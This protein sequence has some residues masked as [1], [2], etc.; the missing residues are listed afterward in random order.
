MLLKTILNESIST[1]KEL[2]LSTFFLAIFNVVF[3]QDINQYNLS[4]NN[5]ALDGYDVVSYFDS[6]KPF[7]GKKSIQ[8]KLNGV[9]YYFA[10]TQNRDRFIK[11]PDKYYVSYG[12]WCAYAMGAKNEKVSVD[13]ETYKIIGGKLYLFYNS[14]YNNTLTKWNKDQENFKHEADFNWNNLIK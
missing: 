6:E 11:S 14:F 2:V 3:G 5:L 13:P 1:M 10:N 7:K 4:T 12:G 8:H 9:V